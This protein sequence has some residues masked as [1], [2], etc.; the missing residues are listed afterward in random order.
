MEELARVTVGSGDLKSAR[1]GAGAQES[2]LPPGVQR[3]PGSRSPSAVGTA[4]FSLKAF[5]DWMRP[6]HI[7][8][9]NLPNSS[10][11]WIWV[12]PNSW[13]MHKL[14]Y[15]NHPPP[16]PKEDGKSFRETLRTVSLP[17]GFPDTSEKPECGRGGVP[18][19]DCKPLLHARWEREGNGTREAPSAPKSP[20]HS[21]ARFEGQGMRFRPQLRM[22]LDLNYC[23]CL[24]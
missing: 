17:A 3:R 10:N 18:T 20:T 8:E 15:C 12:G 24:G 14:K 9:D 4:I 6:T 22:G 7:M 13:V 11:I 23:K 19:L 5:T 21:L 1:G 2:L 16:T